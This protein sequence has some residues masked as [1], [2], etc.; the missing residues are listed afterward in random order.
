MNPQTIIGYTA[1]AKGQALE[2]LTYPAPQLKDHEVRVA[3]SHCGLCYTDIQAIEDFYE[4]T[5]YPFVPGHEVVG[6]VCEVGK[7]VMEL[8]EGDR[9]GIGWQGRACGQCEW[10]ASGEV[11]L[12][13]EVVKNASWT[14]YGGFSTSIKVDAGFAY[15][16]PPK[17]P[18][19]TA[20]VLM[21]AGIS[22]FAPLHQNYTHPAQ[23]IGIIGI[24]GLGHLAIQYA[25]AM[26]YEVTAISSSPGKKEE[27][28]GFGANHFIWASDRAELR[29]AAYYFDVLL[30]TA[31]AGVDWEAMHAILK[32]KGKLLLA[33]FSEMSFKPI[34]LVAHQ[35][36]MT[37]SFL[38]TQD[39]MREM[40]AFSELQNIR[41][42]IELLPMSQINP[43]INK[44]KAGKVRYRMVLEN[45]FVV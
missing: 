20:A 31:H 45:D 1:K 36:T 12:C 30:C 22:V 28:L 24:G 9:V 32:K 21:C 14:P 19:E 26:G 11:N 10:C 27:A 33:G 39:E 18:S 23:R 3:I 34:D 35:L 37:G 41:P 42:L 16:L 25:K 7:S 15:P 13:Q 4:I 43:A 44:L 17:I 40:L 38:G 29:K 6:H 8:R 5:D 2:P